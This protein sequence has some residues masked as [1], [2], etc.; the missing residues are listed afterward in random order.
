MEKEEPPKTCR[1][2]DPV[3]SPLPGAWHV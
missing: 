2:D 3:R 1:D